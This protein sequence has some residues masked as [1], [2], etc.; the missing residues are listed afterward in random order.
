[1]GVFSEIGHTV[2]SSLNPARR[3]MA[4]RR[5]ISLANRIAY[6]GSF[7]M[8]AG[9]GAAAGGIAG[10]IGGGRDHRVSG[11]IGGGILGGGIGAA[12]GLRMLPRGWRKMPG[13][14]L[15]MGPAGWAQGFNYTGRGSGWA[16][17]GAETVYRNV[18]NPLTL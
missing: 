7:A 6:S 4:Q 14:T 8:K 17:A 2:M 13:G 5:A 3:V 11:A 12:T 9:I 18:A 1:M 10:G 16:T 15:H